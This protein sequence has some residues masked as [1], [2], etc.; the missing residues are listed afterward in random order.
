LWGEIVKSR[1]EYES[2]PTEFKASLNQGAIDGFPIKVYS[3][4]IYQGRYT[5]NIPK[6]AWMA[7]M[8]KDLDKHCIL[9]G[10]NYASGCFRASANINGSDWS[11]E[12]HDVVPTSIKT[13]WNEVISF[14]MNST[15]EEFKA[16]LG[17]YFYIDSLIDYL[18]FGLVS[19]GL[20]AF[21]KNQIYMTYDG[22]KWIASMYDMDSTWGL[23]WNGSNILSATY[24][25][26]SYEDFVS[27]REGNLLYM[28]LERL[29]S[30]EIKERYA[31]LKRTVLAVPNIIDCFERFTDIASMEL[32]KEDYASTTGSGK[33]T[34]I[35]S[36]TT[37]NIQQIRDFVVNRFPYCDTYVDNLSNENG[38]GEE[39]G[40]DN[41]TISC[42]GISLNSN[43]LEFT[44]IVAKNLVATLEPN[45]TTDTVNWMSSDTNVAT[46]RG[47]ASECTVTPIANGSATITVTCGEYSAS[48]SVTVSGIAEPIACTGISL[49]KTELV[50]TEEGT[51]TIVA[52]VTPTDTTDA[53]VWSSNNESV[54]TVENG[55]VSV[56]VI[57]GTATITA[58]CG[59]Y[60]ASCNVTVDIPDESVVYSLP[61]ATTFDGTNHI[62]TGVQLFAEDK[63]FTV[64]ID[65]R[66]TGDIEFVSNS[67]VIAH[68]MHETSPFYGLVLQY[69]ANSIQA[70]IKQSE[71]YTILQSKSL[72]EEKIRAVFVKDSSGIITISVNSDKANGIS[73]KSGSC[74]FAAIAETLLLGC[75]Q[76]TSGT[77]GRYAKGVLADCKVYN[78][79]M[80]TEEVEAYLMA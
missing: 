37:N 69:S 8:D 43:S 47:N 62:D 13:R 76:Q 55:V 73:K 32:V 14:V 19:C 61:E 54:A 75:H 63:P 70:E 49:D 52:T 20:D 53:V 65:W 74:T 10:E 5:L 23:Y 7:N 34:G 29:F 36:K 12:V 15:D 1:S 16:N 41:E 24:E 17:N 18:L 6:D 57:S 51:Q 26:T 44:D 66:H 60:S 72:I 68:C 22:Q 77:K 64:C 56:H 78:R 45:N 80:T 40:E 21:G 58:T 31:E 27:G 2:Y 71:K 38:E 67:H 33:F 42:T 28:R 79:A 59:N 50:F 30:E 3:Q 9:C 46:V 39:G 25:R 11:D 4:G 35:P 48:C